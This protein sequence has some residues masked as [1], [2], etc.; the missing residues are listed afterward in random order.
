MY[1]KHL[2]RSML[3]FRLIQTKITIRY[4]YIPKQMAI[5]KIQT[6]IKMAK[7]F[8]TGTVYTAGINVKN[9]SYTEKLCDN[10]LKVKYKF[11]IQLS[12]SSFG[13]YGRQVKIYVSTQNG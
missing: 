12:N 3:D 7:C 8:E 1:I 6:S 13:M 2:K 10:F 11:S 5:S 4:N 9:Y